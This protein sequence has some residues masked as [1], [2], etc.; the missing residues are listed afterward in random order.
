VAPSHE[1]QAERIAPIWDIVHVAETGSTNADLVAAGTSGSAGH[2]RVLVAD[3]QTAGRGR[4]DRRWEASPGA[5]LLVSVL[6]RTGWHYPHELTQR[7]A[8]AA[9]DAAEVLTGVRPTLK[10]PNDLLVSGEKLAGILAQAGGSGGRIEFVVVGM[11]LNLG[12]APDG[13][14][15]LEGVSRDD[16]LHEWLRLMAAQWS[17]PIETRY[18]AQLATLGQ[19]VRVERTGDA[20]EGDAVDVQPDGTLIVCDDHGVQHSVALGDVIHLR[21]A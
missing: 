21:R 7:V 3:H 2:G 9:A 20:L 11:G 15:R 1:R 12:W 14:A 17:D 5:N 8:V 4:L 19:R 13:A 6:F 16:F 18:R 10:W